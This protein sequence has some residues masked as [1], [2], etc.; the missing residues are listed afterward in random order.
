MA[1]RLR[2]VATDA[3]VV[4]GVL[5]DK[6]VRGIDEELKPSRQPPLTHRERLVSSESH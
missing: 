1:D 6:E 4:L 2:H 3:E 5:M